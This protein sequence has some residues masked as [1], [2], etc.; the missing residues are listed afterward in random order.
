MTH[1]DK[2][3]SSVRS[4][5]LGADTMAI[6]HENLSVVLTYGFSLQ[7]LDEYRGWLTSKRWHVLD[8]VLLDL[9]KQV[10]RGP[11]SN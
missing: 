4:P 2:S 6:I 1:V 8:S 11:S 10:Q 7:A 3:P 5:A 9:P